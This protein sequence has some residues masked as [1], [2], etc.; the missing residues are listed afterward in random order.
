MN[1]SSPP[2][3]EGG[4]FPPEATAA[5][6]DSGKT[7]ETLLS[8]DSPVFREVAVTLKVKLGQVSMSVEELLALRVGSNVVLDRKIDQPADL[9]LNQTLVARGEIVAID[10]SFGIRI[11]EIAER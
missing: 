9:Y 4:G 2:R 10:G 11:V 3:S 8:I 7:G 5:T 6:E 1:D